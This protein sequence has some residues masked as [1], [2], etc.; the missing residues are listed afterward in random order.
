MKK[1]AQFV[2]YGEDNNSNFPE[3]FDLWK[4]NLLS[5]YGSVSHL[6]IQG[7]PGTIFYL[8]NSSKNEISIGA[9]GVYELDLE[10]LGYITALN[11]DSNILKTKYINNGNR[12]IVDIVYE[13][14][15]KI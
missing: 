8:N 9:T 10:G 5:N 15:Y 4:Y 14:G 2:F 12:L 7:E 1:I 6:G 3:D 11:F 13:E